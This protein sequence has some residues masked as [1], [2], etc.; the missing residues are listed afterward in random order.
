MGKMITKLKNYVEKEWTQRKGGTEFWCYVKFC[1]A[2]KYIVN[3]IT[4]RGIRCLAD[5]I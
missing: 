2:V 5:C 1:S 3:I 4:G